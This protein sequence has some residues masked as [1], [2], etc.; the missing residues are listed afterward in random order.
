MCLFILPS[1]ILPIDTVKSI[2]QSQEGPAKSAVS[3]AAGLY[4]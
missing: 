1:A 4:K 3:V 2:V